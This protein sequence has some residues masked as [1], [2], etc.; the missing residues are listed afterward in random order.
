MQDLASFHRVQLVNIAKSKTKKR[1]V[2]HLTDRQKASSS[3]G[4]IWGGIIIIGI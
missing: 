2:E 1:K 4:K 3:G